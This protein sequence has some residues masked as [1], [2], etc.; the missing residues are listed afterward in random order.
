MNRFFYFLVTIVLGEAILSEM[1][2]EQRIQLY[3]SPFRWI[4][5]KILSL[6]EKN[7]E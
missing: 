4:K 1:T 3:P 5:N 6:G 7:N 2:K